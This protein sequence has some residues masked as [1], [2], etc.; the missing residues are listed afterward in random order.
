MKQTGNPV[1][2]TEGTPK[3]SATVKQQ[4]VQPQRYSWQP[5]VIL[6]VY[7][8]LLITPWI[9][10]CVVV[11]R[12][13]RDGSVTIRQK[14]LNIYES[15]LDAVP[16]I[17]TVAAVITIPFVSALLAHGAAV[18]AQRKNMKQRVTLRQLIGLADRNWVTIDPTHLH[19]AP[20]DRSLYLYLAT[21]LLLISVVQL[22]LR[23]YLAP[24]DSR[25]AFVCDDT[26]EGSK[27]TPS[28]ESFTSIFAADT[29]STGAESLAFDID[30]GTI[31]EMHRQPMLD[32]IDERL[33]TVTS[34]SIQPHLWRGNGTDETI[35][36]RE[37]FAA[38]PIFQNAFWA[39]SAPSG[40]TTGG[41]RLHSLRLN[42]SS[43]CESIGDDQFPSECSGQYPFS[44]NYTGNGISIRVCV[45]DDKGGKP[46]EAHR[47]RQ[48]IE[49][50][51]YL[52]A[53][54]APDAWSTAS[55]DEIRN[56]TIR[57]IGR[58]TLGYFELG[59]LRNGG[60]PSEL[61]A[62]WPSSEEMDDFD[63]YLADYPLTRDS[64]Y[65]RPGTST[66]P[67][68]PLQMAAEG[69]FG[70]QSYHYTLLQILNSTETSIS[71]SLCT[72]LKP[73]MVGLDYPRPPAWVASMARRCNATSV[74]K[75]NLAAEAHKFI[76]GFLSQ[77]TADSA[78]GVT[79]FFANEALLTSADTDRAYGLRRIIDKPPIS[80]RGANA[81]HA[82]IIAVSVLLGVQVLLLI[83]LTG[84]I[85]TQRT[86]TGTLDAFAMLR[87]GAA[88]KGTVALP[89]LQRASS[90][91]LKELGKV[92]GFGGLVPGYQDPNRDVEVMKQ[93]PETSTA[94]LDKTSPSSSTQVGTA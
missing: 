10:I 11:T 75:E 54:A 85:Y 25:P 46:W 16:V 37:G 49:E 13:P 67:S 93:D 27:W 79:M 7:V 74:P 45:P 23:T 43:E 6:I 28:C 48:D 57:C 68:G 94:P 81:S 63:D 65:D 3:A 92:D 64:N 52:E 24:I 47:D 18:Y 51:M 76:G 30:P 9:L 87:L 88:V 31:A 86:W 56:V 62:E 34:R 39:S 12:T 19:R 69:L 89:G 32:A 77:E 82:A 29:S 41:L 84:Y 20:G 71:G 5:L 59:N 83:L 4:H 35:V 66:S 21:V 38:V 80:F 70:P 73:P 78:L 72:A 44:A 90:A 40:S 36:A 91:D 58:S 60:Q 42:S 61:L 50:E 1:Q 53:R 8:V 15:W 22:P 55:G 2:A 33:R 26:H 14:D 17:D